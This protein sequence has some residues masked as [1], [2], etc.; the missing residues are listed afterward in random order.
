MPK[1]LTCCPDPVYG[2]GMDEI[3]WLTLAARNLA[4]CKDR[5][6]DLLVPCNGCFATF[7]KAV[8]ELKDLRVREEVNSYLK[9]LGLKYESPPNFFHILSFLDMIGP[10][11][12]KEK[13]IYLL[14]G[15]RVGVHYGCRKDSGFDGSGGGPL[16]RKVAV[17]RRFNCYL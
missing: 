3:Q 8:N 10:D 5:G 15:L 9:Q 7:V 1:G 17:L 2:R 11:R 14:G 16:Q 4:I 6:D 12:L 13:S